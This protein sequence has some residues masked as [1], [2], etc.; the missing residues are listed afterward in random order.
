M[1][2]H[3]RFVELHRLGNSV[4]LGPARSTLGRRVLCSRRAVS[5]LGV[6]VLWLEPFFLGVA[7]CVSCHH[8]VQRTVQ[9]VVIK[10]APEVI[11]RA[12][13]MNAK[14]YLFCFYWL[15]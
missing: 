8:L 13:I 14:M 9:W 7:V 3:V 12:S 5:L 11:D 15:H 10:P 6:L 2:R 1:A 4:S